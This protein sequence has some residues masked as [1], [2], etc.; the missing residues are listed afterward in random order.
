MGFLDGILG[1]DSLRDSGTGFL[2]GISG[3]DSW[4][5]F[6]DG[7]LKE[8]MRLGAGDSWEICFGCCRIL[9]GILRGS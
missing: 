9:V 3:W 7:I 2:D 4:M 5:G 8:N 1:W 6:L